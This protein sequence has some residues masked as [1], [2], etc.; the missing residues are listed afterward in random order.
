MLKCVNFCGKIVLTINER[1]I[2]MKTLLKIFVILLCISLVSGCGV[3]A[4]SGPVPQTDKTSTE[5]AVDPSATEI[6]NFFATFVNTNERP[7]AIM[8]DNDDK[9]A[10]PHA[11]LDDAYLIYEMVVEGGATRFLALF[12]GTDT[13][14]IGPVRSSRHY[15]LDY[16]MENDAIY[17]HFGWSPKAITDISAYGINKIN[18]VLGTDESIF[19]REQKFK[20]DWHSAYTSI[21]KIKAMAKQKGYSTE[22]DRKNGIKYSDKYINLPSENSAKSVKLTYSGGYNTGYTYDAEKGVYQKSIN[23][24]PHSLQKGNIV[25]VKNIIVVLVHDSSLGDGTDRRNINTAGSG[26]GYYITNGGFE[27]I[28][29]SKPSR[30]SNTTYKK[31]DG[32]DLLINPGKT[33]INLISPSADITIQ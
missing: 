13:E 1:R 6:E 18:G 23:G 7:V 11:G 14:K 31:A 9:N 12:R 30:S 22:T 4:P 8:V 20:G 33:I 15:F 21:E 16:V 5:V 17:T 24:A 28:T 25:E 2:F 32:S 19:W 27:E 29:W 10:R 26:K 3:K